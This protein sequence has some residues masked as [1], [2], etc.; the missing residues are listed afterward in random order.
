MKLN[1]DCIRDAMLILEEKLSFKD[2]DRA[3]SFGS[4]SVDCLMCI[5]EKCGYSRDDIAYTALQLFESKY[6]VTDRASPVD[7]K[8]RWLDIGN[9]LYITPAGHEFIASVHNKEVWKDKISPILGA[10]GSVSLSVIEAVSKGIANA[11]IERLMINP[12]TE[13]P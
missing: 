2:Y 1:P 4:M 13:S 11:A 8:M 9:I 10:L 6:I 7:S 5:M 3:I 12:P